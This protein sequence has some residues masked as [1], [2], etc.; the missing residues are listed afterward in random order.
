MSDDELSG[1]STISSTASHT[2][3]QGRWSGF[4]KTVKE[5]KELITLILFFAAGAFWLF[6]YFATKHQVKQLQ[7]LVNANISFL[8]GR[9]DSGS[10]SQLLVDNLKDSA[11]LDMKPTLTSDETLK[12]NQLRVRLE[13]HEERASRRV[14][15]STEAA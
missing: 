8:Q 5:Y 14:S 11:L 12:R 13:S 15:S 9:M 2:T 4:L 7:C 6:D 3:E 10:L 1:A